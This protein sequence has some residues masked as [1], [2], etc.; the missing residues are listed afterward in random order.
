MPE[1]PVT[2]VTVEALTLLHGLIKQDA[3][4]TSSNEASCH[5]TNPA[6]H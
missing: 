2:P 1:T 6:F 5:G 3:Y 4:A